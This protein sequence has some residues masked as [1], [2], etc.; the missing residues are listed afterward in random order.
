MII[1]AASIVFHSVLLVGSWSESTAAMARVYLLSIS[2]QH[3]TNQIHN[4]YVN[5]T[6]STAMHDAADS[7]Y[8][9]VRGGYFGLCAR[10]NNKGSWTCKR[11]AAGFMGNRASIEDP[12][13]L[14][15]IMDHFRG[16]VEFPGLI[17]GSIV[18]STITL[19]LIST[20]PGYHEEEEAETGDFIEVKP[21]PSRPISQAAAASMAFSTLF[22]LVAALWQHTAAASAASVLQYAT[23]GNIKPSVGP[24]AVVLVWMPVAMAATVCVSILVMIFGITLLD[25]LVD[26][27]QSSV[28]IA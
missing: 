26:D 5:Q 22:A 15:G 11:N 16:E 18:L 14:L 10:S 12:L 24:T 28:N 21:F 20:F 3:Q 25:R 1:T 8:L 19:A 7:A 13:N 27:D 9:E 4:S 6:L 2:Y 23:L 17:L